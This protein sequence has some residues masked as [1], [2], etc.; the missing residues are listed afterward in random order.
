MKTKKW[1]IPVAICLLLSFITPAYS[2]L[3]KQPA[4]III[5]HS[6]V[7][8]EEEDHPWNIDDTELLS[9]SENIPTIDENLGL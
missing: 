1:S 7:E 8:K 3:F 6:T 2:C 5:K 4:D 9:F